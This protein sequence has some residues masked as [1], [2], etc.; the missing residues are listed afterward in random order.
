MPFSPAQQRY[1]RRIV[2]LSIAYALLLFLAIWLF[3]RHLMAGLIA[4]LF[5]ILPAIPVSGFFWMIWSRRATNICACCRS[6][7]C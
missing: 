5:A 7:S 4:Y 1:K 2:M 3:S 6:A